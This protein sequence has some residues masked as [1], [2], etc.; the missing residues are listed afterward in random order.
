MNASHNQLSQIPL[1]FFSN[2]PNV[3]EID[4]SFNELTDHKLVELPKLEKIHFSHN[5]MSSIYVSQF[6]AGLKYLDL[7]FNPIHNINADILH[8]LRQG[9]SIDISWKHVNFYLFERIKEPIHITV[10]SEKE[11]FSHTSEDSIELHCN[12]MSF[13]NV[14]SLEMREI[15]I[16]NLPDIM[17]CLTP[18]IRVLDLSDS[19]LE[20]LNSK[21][22]ARFYN[23]EELKLR[24][25]KLNEFD[26]AWLR[27]LKKLKTIDIG[28]N[29]LKTVKNA[30]FLG[31]FEDITT[32]NL[33][34]N[35]MNNA[36]EVLQHL[37][38]SI[39][40]LHLS[41]SSVGQLNDTTFQKLTNLK[42]LFLIGTNLSF[43]NMKP[44]Q[45]LHKIETLRIG[46]NGLVTFDV[47]SIPGNHLIDLNLSGNNLY[48]LENITKTQ[49]PKLKMLTLS[50]NMF[51]C[52]YLNNLVANIKHEF[53]A[54]F[55]FNNV[56]QQKHGDCIPNK[57][58]LQHSQIQN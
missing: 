34:E 17:R 11:G 35:E 4:F 32:L 55:N 31:M 53:G 5:Q 19:H 39:E 45:A 58:F 41:G 6:E 7:T 57:S 36:N 54:F 13:E 3:V 16:D 14:Q 10:G 26:F 37:N 23:L 38:P 21:Y 42:E 25:G 22:F 12:E 9:I 47:T 48:K 28:G 18:S 43:P 30:S 49:F 1:A 15:H 24:N 33:E 27:K 50:Q 2:T 46:Y 8:L 56:W 52:D 29:N 40:V 51:P 44:F 20:K